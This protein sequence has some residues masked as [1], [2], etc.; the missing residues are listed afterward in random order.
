M[1]VATRAVSPTATPT[2][3]VRTGSA[4]RPWPGSSASRTPATAVG[5]IDAR[6]NAPAATDGLA[7]GISAVPSPKPVARAS[8][9][10]ANAETPMTTAIKAAAPTSNAVASNAIPGC[11]SAKRGFPI[12][13]SEDNR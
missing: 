12:G 6:A 2:S 10:P 1:N 5:G 8:R 13:A 7:L 9:H 4:V 3:V 11:G